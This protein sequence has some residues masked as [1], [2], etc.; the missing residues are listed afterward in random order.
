MYIN[1]VDY[2][3]KWARS[4]SEQEF[5]SRLT[6]VLWPEL[7]E[8]IRKEKLAA[9]Y[10]LITDKKVLP[11]KAKQMAVQQPEETKVKKGAE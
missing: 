9:A 2:D 11:A 1:D 6:P 3:E 7:P 4:V 10:A 5:V 8:L